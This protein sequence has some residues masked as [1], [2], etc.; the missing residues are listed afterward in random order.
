MHLDL[1]QQIQLM[2]MGKTYSSLISQSIDRS[3]EED[4]LR[5]KQSHVLVKRGPTRQLPQLQTHIIT[6]QQDHN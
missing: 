4:L 1:Y 3:V 5:E 6:F 2:V